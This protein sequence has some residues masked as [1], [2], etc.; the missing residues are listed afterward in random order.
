[1]SRIA[2]LTALA[3]V[4]FTL[5]ANPLTGHIVEP[6]H[7]SADDARCELRV[8]KRGGAT[9]LEGVVI[10]SK[11]LSGSYRISVA[12]SGG[13]NA[14][15]IDQSGAFSAS[16]GQPVS[17]GVV[18]LGGPGGYSA[19]LTVKWGGGSTRCSGRG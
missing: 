13:A 1:M 9:T 4:M 15:D 18:Q 5:G 3:P 2:C 14:S 11:A 7:A 16:P 6:A 17:L 8:S 10:A 12:A 19:N